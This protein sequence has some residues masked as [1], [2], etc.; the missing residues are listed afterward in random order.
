MS[1]R[2]SS[3]SKWRPARP[4]SIW[5]IRSC[6][7]LARPAPGLRSSAWRRSGAAIAH[8]FALL[9]TVRIE[10]GTRAAQRVAGGSAESGRSAISFRT[11]SRRSRR[12]RP[13]TRSS[14]LR[15]TPSAC[16]AW[17]VRGSVVRTSR[18]SL[19]FWPGGRCQRAPNSVL[20][21]FNFRSP[22][23]IRS[24]HPRTPARPAASP[25]TAAPRPAG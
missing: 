15:P 13:G 16:R 11:R 9:P 20:D 19:G 8:L 25:P 17:P 12:T 10:H 22:P 21:Q 23:S 3:R 2:R 6:R 18:G 24:E 1:H 7:T 14:R 4:S 5:P